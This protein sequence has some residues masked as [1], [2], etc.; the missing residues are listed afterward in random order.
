MLR[1]VETE[2]I[3]AD[4][5]TVSS[6]HERVARRAQAGDADAR[7]IA[8]LYE[9]AEQ[10]LAGGNP[11]RSLGEDLSEGLRDLFL[12][13]SVPVVYVAN[14]SDPEETHSAHVDRLRSYAADARAELVVVA[15][16]LEAEIAQLDASDR[17]EFLAEM[18]VAESGLERVAHAAFDA[19]GLSVFFTTT[20]GREARAWPFPAGTT[21]GQA[22]GMIHTDFEKGFVRAEVITYEDYVNLGSEHG[23]ARR[24]QDAHRGPRPHH[25]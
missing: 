25:W 24:R 19:L 17:D 22:A 13:T 5:D 11:A 21:A 10:H 9:E 7:R 23:A 3:L 18:G 16:E 20:G 14:V 15:A 12:L 1:F 8:H 4:L 6:A 2:L